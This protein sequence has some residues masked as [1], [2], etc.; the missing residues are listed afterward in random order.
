MRPAEYL[1]EDD[2][3][4]ALTLEREDYSDSQSSILAGGMDDLDDRSKDILQRRWL[5][6]EK[7]T[8]QELAD[9]YQVS[10]ERIRQIEKAAMNKL[11]THIQSA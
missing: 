10:A 1:F 4:P 7:A 2:S 3:D 8:L 5:Q 11:K 6:D 9:E